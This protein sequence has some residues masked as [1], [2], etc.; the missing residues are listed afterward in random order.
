VGAKPM[1]P[2]FIGGI[3]E[4]VHLYKQNAAE[5][6]AIKILQL[7]SFFLTRKAFLL[8]LITVGHGTVLF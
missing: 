5:D 7:S 1:F 2:P 6:P 4:L 8:A 3:L